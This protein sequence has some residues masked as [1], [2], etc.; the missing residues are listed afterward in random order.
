VH[1]VRLGGRLT[2][3]SI[4][5]VRPPEPNPGRTVFLPPDAL[6]LLI[7]VAGSGKS[8][9][10]RAH[11]APSEIVSSDALRALIAGDPSDQSA[12]A[13]AFDLLHRILAMRLRRGLLTVVDATNVE[14]WARAQLLDVAWRARRPAVAIILDPGIAVALE[15]NLT[16]A[17][18]RRPPAAVRRQQ[19]WLEQGLRDIANEGFAAVEHLREPD[20]RVIIERVAPSAARE[21][22][23][24]TLRPRR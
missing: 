15:R 12:T 20:P 2:A 19:R 13:D 10:A 3:R 9:F 4:D 21:N 17:D 16:R 23:E 1:G 22:P 14:A 24:G 11:F 7:G 18:G 5:S 6:V 8:T